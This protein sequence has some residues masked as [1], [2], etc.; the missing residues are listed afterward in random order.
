M[1]A[2][3][4][5]VV[6][7]FESKEGDER[8]FSKED[9]ERAGASLGLD[10][11]NFSDIRYTYDSR[12]D[13]PRGNWAIVGRGK[14]K[15]AF[16]K[17]EKKN[18]I[19]I[20]ENIAGEIKTASEISDHTP[21]LIRPYIGDDEQ[22]TLTRLTYSDAIQRVL[23]LDDLK[24]LQDHCRTF[25]STGQ[26]ELDELCIG[27]RNGEKLIVPISAKGGKDNL[28]YSHIYHIHV[29]CREKY[30]ELKPLICGM[31]KA[32][33]GNI[34][35][36]VFEGNDDINKI[37]ILEVHC[38]SLREPMG[39]IPDAWR[40]WFGDLAHGAEAQAIQAFIRED[41]QKHKI[42]PSPENLWNAFTHTRPSSV[43][44]VILGQDPYPDSAAAHGLAF[45]SLNSIPASLSNIY[46]EIRR[47]H[48][49]IKLEHGDLTCWAKQ[50]VLLLNS[51]LTVQAG[52]PGSHSH[53]WAD[54]TD[55]I[56]SR[57]SET[58]TGVVFVL[59]GAKAKA[60]S[61]LIDSKKHLILTAA[62]PSP[63]SAAKFAGC[64]HFQ[65]VNE[66]LLQTGRPAINWSVCNPVV[67]E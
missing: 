53:V 7:V 35:L 57:L 23:K 50:G 11:K 55:K 40:E 2:Y 12:E 16:V 30:P 60:K 8:P 67:D 32:V 33:D 3:E 25:T 31:Y 42:N 56:I 6:S 38:V 47:T 28:S 1:S 54:Y 44:V 62:H 13:F 9:M 27:E 14:G 4:K 63:L 52:N 58:T 15:Y 64:N 45:S 19:R 46:K 20:P 36:L 65:L 66:Y 37:K 22:A 61:Q 48:P 17:L 5:V 43:K 10:I 24:R 21:D 49:D 18:L 26:I 39:K 59:W 51:A 41:A 34:F 29:F